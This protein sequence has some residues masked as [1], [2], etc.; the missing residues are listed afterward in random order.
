M[1]TGAWSRETHTHTHRERE[2]ERELGI[3][4]WY[5]NLSSRTFVFRREIL[6]RFLMKRRSVLLMLRRESLWCWISDVFLFW[7]ELKTWT[8]S[9]PFFYDRFYDTWSREI[10]WAILLCFVGKFVDSQGQKSKKG[11]MI[12]S[13]ITWDSFFRTLISLSLSKNTCCRRW[14]RRKR[15]RWWRQRS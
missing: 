15:R 14:R 10:F 7:W 3:Y 5:I 13:R 1:N 6:C 4:M 8:F 12:D 11:T 2:R 9:F